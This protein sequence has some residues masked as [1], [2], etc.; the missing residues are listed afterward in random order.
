MAFVECF[1]QACR[2][3]E[4]AD[5][6]PGVLSVPVNLLVNKDQQGIFLATLQLAERTIKAGMLQ[7]KT[8]LLRVSEVA[9]VS[10][11]LEL[12]E[13]SDAQGHCRVLLQGRAQF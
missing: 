3:G 13:A 6:L 2:S 7:R 5:R 1:G 8:P 10:K 11:L 9:R 4:E 12:A